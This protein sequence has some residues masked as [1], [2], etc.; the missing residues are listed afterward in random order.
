MRWELII[1][2]S[3]ISTVVSESQRGPATKE[4]GSAASKL[5]IAT[6]ATPEGQRGSLLRVF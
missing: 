5:P 4:E 2:T 6:T 3:S 1:G